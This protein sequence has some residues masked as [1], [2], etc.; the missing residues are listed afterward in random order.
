MVSPG[1]RIIQHYAMRFLEQCRQ[2]DV[3]P[4]N[5]RRLKHLQTTFSLSGQSKKP[6]QMEVFYFLAEG[7]LKV[8]QMVEVQPSPQEKKQVHIHWN[9]DLTDLILE[10]YTPVRESK[11]PKD[12]ENVINQYKESSLFQE[13]MAER[14]RMAKQLRPLR[15][16]PVENP[17]VPT[18]YVF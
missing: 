4:P 18:T 9:T 1:K 5:F 8:C 3:W 6:A 11:N 7:C 10:F 13:F 12:L 14:R 16:K 15:L 2:P 17:P